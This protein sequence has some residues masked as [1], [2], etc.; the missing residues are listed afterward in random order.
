MAFTLYEIWSEDD[1]GRQELINT[2]ANLPEAIR[3]A[4]NSICDE[5]TQTVI[6]EEGL[7]GEVFEIKRFKKD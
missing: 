4:K 6:F 7:D 1:D 2:A 5:V 3:I